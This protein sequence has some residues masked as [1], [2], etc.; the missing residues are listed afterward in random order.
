M[1]A[2][3]ERRSRVFWGSLGAATIAMTWLTGRKAGGTINNLLPYLVIAFLAAGEAWLVLLRRWPRSRWTAPALLLVVTALLA[4][5]A[6]RTHAMN[7]ALEAAHAVAPGPS[8]YRQIEEFELRLTDTLSRYEGPVFVGGRF[9]ALVTL[10]RPVENFHQTALFEG[11]VRAPLYDVDA[12]AGKALRTHAFEALIVWRRDREGA[13][14]QLIEQS[15][16]LRES[17]GE[18]PLIGLDVEVWEPR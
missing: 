14:R 3:G 8:A 13:F 1:L 9:W 4:E 16:V 5:D 7:A 12:I 11:T 2:A 10:G 15:Y 18:D 17:L 6:R